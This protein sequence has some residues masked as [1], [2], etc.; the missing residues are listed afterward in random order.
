MTRSAKVNSA[1]QTDVSGLKWFKIY[2]DGYD[3][4]T[5]TWAVDKMIANKGKVSFKIPDCIASG[6]YLLRVEM[7]ALHSASSYPGAQF[8]VRSLGSQSRCGMRKTDLELD[9]FI[10][11]VCTDQDKRRW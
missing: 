7:I 11:G 6:E 10:D 8:Y 1:T 3:P 9:A 2:E 5:K 4:S